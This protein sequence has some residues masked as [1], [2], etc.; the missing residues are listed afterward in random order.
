MIENLSQPTS[1]KTEKTAP[2]M[3]AQR[4][5]PQQQLCIPNLIFRYFTIGN[6]NL[7]H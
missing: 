2:T 7:S 1:G 3:H 4:T 5:K 6:K